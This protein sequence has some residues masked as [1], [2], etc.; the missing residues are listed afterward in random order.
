MNIVENLIS[1]EFS[2]VID[3]D[4]QEITVKTLKLDIYSNR[5]KDIQLISKTG[6]AKFLRLKA[7]LTREEASLLENKCAV[8]LCLANHLQGAVGIIGYLKNFSYSFATKEIEI[9]IKVVE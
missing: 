3:A 8:S 9:L 6:K 2:T 5:L 4:I 1:V 7:I